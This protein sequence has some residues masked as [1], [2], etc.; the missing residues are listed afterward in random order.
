ME[1]LLE[2][3]DEIIPYILSGVYLC[4]RMSATNSKRR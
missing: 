4:S 3:T 2:V 1:V